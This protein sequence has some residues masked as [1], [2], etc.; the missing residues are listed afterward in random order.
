MTAKEFIQKE[1]VDGIGKI[2][3]T[4]PFLACMAMAAGIEFLGKCLDPVGLWDEDGKST[5]DFK[6]AINKLFPSYSQTIDSGKLYHE[7]RCGLLHLCV[8]KNGLALSD[9][10]KNLREETIG[11]KTRIVIN[12]KQLYEDFKNACNEVMKNSALDSKTSK[13]FYTVETYGGASITGST[14]VTKTNNSDKSKR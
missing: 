1:L 8:P 9:N 10:G 2:I 7:L 4:S 5:D 6:T 12:C 13:E 3:N 14:C 11:N